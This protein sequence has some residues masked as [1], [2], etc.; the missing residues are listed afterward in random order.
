MQVEQLE[1]KKEK[2]QRSV[3]F[4]ATQAFSGSLCPLSYGCRV[5][6][7]PPCMDEQRLKLQPGDRVLVSR[8]RKFVPIAFLSLFTIELSHPIKPSKP[9]T[10]NNVCKRTGLG[11]ETCQRFLVVSVDISSSWAGFEYLVS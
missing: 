4:E 7:C 2:R 8:F 11:L 9:Q 5:G 3:M 1:Q 6:C 10:L